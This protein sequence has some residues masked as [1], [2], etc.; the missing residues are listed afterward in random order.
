MGETHSLW[1]RLKDHETLSILT[2][3][4]CGGLTGPREHCG[5]SLCVPQALITG[6]LC[7]M[8]SILLGT[9]DTMEEKQQASCP[10][11]V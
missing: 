2:H 3:L 11:G 6:P 10:K 7:V 5:N 8:P 4:P 9:E 1:T